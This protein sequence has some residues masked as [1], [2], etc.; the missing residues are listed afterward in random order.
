MENLLPLSFRVQIRSMI[1]EG[2]KDVRVQCFNG[3]RLSLLIFNLR[4]FCTCSLGEI[5]SSSKGQL[6]E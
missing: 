5:Y 4:I 2:E 3:L 6:S 1:N